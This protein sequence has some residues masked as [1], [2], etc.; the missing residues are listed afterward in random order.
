[1]ARDNEIEFSTTTNPFTNSD[2]TTD[3]EEKKYALI[4]FHGDSKVSRMLVQKRCDELGYE[5]IFFPCPNTEDDENSSESIARLTAFLFEHNEKNIK[6][7]WILADANYSYG[8]DRMKNPNVPLLQHILNSVKP[9]FLFVTSVTPG[10][11]ENVKNNTELTGIYVS[12]ISYQLITSTVPVT[13]KTQHQLSSDSSTMLDVKTELKDNV[14][15][16]NNHSNNDAVNKLADDI[17]SSD[18]AI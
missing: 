16:N 5:A 13:L 14:R 2:L 4:M 8:G 11:L 15:N 10:C 6:V 1:M 9:D 18:F 12:D 17:A 3:S 7:S